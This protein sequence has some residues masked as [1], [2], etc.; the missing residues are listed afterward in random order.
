MSDDLKIGQDY[1][2]KYPFVRTK[3]RVYDDIDSFKEIES[4]RPGTEPVIYGDDT[5]YEADGVGEMILHLVSIH[6]PGKYP[7]RVF[8]TR[9][10]KDPDG[11]VWGKKELKVTTQGNFRQ[12][13]KGFRHVYDLR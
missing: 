11:K 5:E 4:M 1:S 8:Y 3:Y 9:R 6:K 13:L 2:C 12:M 10:W 7:T